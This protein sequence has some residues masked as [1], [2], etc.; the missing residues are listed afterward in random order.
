MGEQHTMD[1]PR[2]MSWLHKKPTKAVPLTDAWIALRRKERMEQAGGLIELHPDVRRIPTPL[3]NV[4]LSLGG[5]GICVA[6][7]IAHGWL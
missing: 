3:I 2:D 5:L 1:E 4:L 7:W 6:V